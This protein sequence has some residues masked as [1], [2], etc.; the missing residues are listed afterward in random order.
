MAG[1]R[2]RN[3][4]LAIISGLYGAVVTGSF[5]GFSVYSKALK[6]Q[7]GLNTLSVKTPSFVALFK[8]Q[9]LSPLAMFQFFTSALW[10]MDEYWQYCLFSL[11][12]IAPPVCII[13]T[14][15]ARFRSMFSSIPSGHGAA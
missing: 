15:E 10:L 12:N 14:A 1:D 5:Y 6:A 2:T 11:L 3:A 7:F 8:E 9:L 13:S 4:R